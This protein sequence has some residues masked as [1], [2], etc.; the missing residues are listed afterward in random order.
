M[1]GESGGKVA[2]MMLAWHW[3]WAALAGVLATLAIIVLIVV[4]SLIHL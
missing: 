3:P 4:L 2:F 1:G